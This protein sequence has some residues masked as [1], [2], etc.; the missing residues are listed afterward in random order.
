MA[1]LT[2]LQIIDLQMEALLPTM[3]RDLANRLGVP[4]NQLSISDKELLRVMKE[5]PEALFP[6]ES[7]E[8]ESRRLLIPDELSPD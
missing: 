4:V 1:K 6:D 2:H 3:R 5:S 7:G 8:W